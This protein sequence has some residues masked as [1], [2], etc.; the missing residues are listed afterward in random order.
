MT[1]DLTPTASVAG[2]R[3]LQGSAV[4]AVVF[5]L[6]QI[7]SR[8]CVSCPERFPPTLWLMALGIYL[9][10]ALLSIFASSFR[11]IGFVLAGL[12]GSHAAFVVYQAGLNQFCVSCLVLHGIG[13]ALFS[14]SIFI[15]A[16]P[17][18]YAF[19]VAT[20]ALVG[21]LLIISLLGIGHP[22]TH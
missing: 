9:I 16:L 22:R 21:T 12:G 18:P 11:I 1:R 8:P 15:R 6:F 3:L 17:R 13:I 4:G 2:N 14:V 7:A 5:C 19:G 20:S 10:V